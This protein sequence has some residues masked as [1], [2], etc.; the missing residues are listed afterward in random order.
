MLRHRLTPEEKKDRQRDAH[1]RYMKTEKGKQATHRQKENQRRASALWKIRHPD[2]HRQYW[3]KR[4]GLTLAQFDELAKNGCG[5]CGTHSDLAVDHNHDT[6]KVRGV[7]CRKHNT[8]IGLLDDNP[9]LV[10]RAL[11]WLEERT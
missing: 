6:G 7:L 10:S 3:L 4:Y 9:Y 2:Y 11:R 8:A 5:I 1:R